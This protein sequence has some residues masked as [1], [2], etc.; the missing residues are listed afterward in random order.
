MRR[1]IR[2]PFWV[3]FPEGSSVAHVSDEYCRGPDI[4]TKIMVTDG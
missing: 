1:S 4:I 3:Y 2:G